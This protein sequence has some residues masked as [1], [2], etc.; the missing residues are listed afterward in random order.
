MTLTL[1]SQIYATLLCEVLPQAITTEAENERAL[2]TVEALMNKTELTPEEDRL[3]D[4]LLVLIE[5]FEHENYPLQNLS[6]PHSSLL[7]LLESN[8]L[9]Q[10]DLS[11]V[12]GSS[13]I[14]S[15]VISGKRKISK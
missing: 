5:K 14:V 8:H 3:Y 12:F 10:T 1:D 9:K 15:E 4:L 6:T 2:A 13:G 7:H 11:D